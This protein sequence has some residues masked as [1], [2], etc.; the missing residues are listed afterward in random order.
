MTDNLPIVE[1]LDLVSKNRRRG[2]E[3]GMYFGNY[4]KADV[5]VRVG[6]LDGELV[7][8]AYVAKAE[9]PAYFILLQWENGR[10]ANIRDF[11]YV[12]YIAREADFEV[13]GAK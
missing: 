8:A 2:K 13:L 12:P 9:A 11:R 1:K 6:R 7:L 10:V 4:E 3:V 5:S